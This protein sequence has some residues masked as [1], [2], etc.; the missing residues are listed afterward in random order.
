MATLSKQGHEIARWEVTT[1]DRA[2]RY[3]LRTNGKLLRQMKICGRYEN[4]TIYHTLTYAINED[5]AGRVEGMLKSLHANA[6]IT[7]Y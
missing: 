7:R 4:W 2:M 1:G 5:S 3:T 6:N